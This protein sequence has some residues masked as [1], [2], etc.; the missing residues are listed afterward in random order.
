MA[1][2][3]I[4]EANPIKIV[5]PP[6]TESE[7]PKIYKGNYDSSYTMENIAFSGADA[8]ATILVP[9]IGEN[10]KVVSNGDVI[11]LGEIQTISY[12]I[13]RE[14]SPVRTL[15]HVNPRGFVKGSRTIAGSLIFTVFNEYVFYRIKQYRDFLE[16][17]NGFF[18]PLAD[19]LPPFDIILTF[20]NEYGQGSKMKIFG[21]TI[22]DEGQT[23]SIDDLIVE[24]TYTFMARGIQPMVKLTTE[25]PNSTRDPELVARDISISNNIFGD[26]VVDNLAKLYQSNMVDRV[27]TFKP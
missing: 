19:M 4:Y 7:D 17:K 22:V 8:V 15:G 20:F 2:D 25:V 16:R 12:S 13:H 10:G 9:V 27:I 18:A 23:I 3:G 5:K 1:S 24:Q 26:T 14:N 21:V 11:E 6:V